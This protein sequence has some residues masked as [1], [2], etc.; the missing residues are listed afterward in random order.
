[1]SGWE[2]QLGA[3]RLP[4]MDGMDAV[5]SAFRDCWSDGA[6][7]CVRQGLRFGATRCW[8]NLVCTLGCVGLVRIRLSPQHHRH[9]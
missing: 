2:K 9:R 1:M 6:G 4:A 5:W 3:E 7:G 8:L